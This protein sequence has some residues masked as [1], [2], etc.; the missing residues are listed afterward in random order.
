[1]VNKCSLRF[2]WN[3]PCFG[4]CPLPL[5]LA[6]GTTE[7]SL[8]LLS[9]HSLFSYSYTFSSLC[10]LQAE[11]FQLSPLEWSSSQWNNDLKINKWRFR[12]GI[13]WKCFTG[14]LVRCWNMLLPR[15]VMISPSL[16]VQGQIGWG[17]GQPDLRG[18]E[19]D[20]L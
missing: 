13:R 6:L 1:M 9:L 20:G 11:E 4:L 16:Q 3:P 14:R 12:L 2:R 17:P 18:L 7:K 8:A 5:F 19:L 10:I 15:E